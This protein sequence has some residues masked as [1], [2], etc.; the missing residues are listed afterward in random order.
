MELQLAAG[1]ALVAHVCVM[2]G[3][4]VPVFVGFVLVGL[5]VFVFFTASG[6]ARPC[7][8]KAARRRMKRCMT[9]LIVDSS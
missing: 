6:W 1:V 2:M 4:G 5:G 7:A 8:A 3:G 9:L